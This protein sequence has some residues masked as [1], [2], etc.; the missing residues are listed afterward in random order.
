MDR[1]MA[2]Q[3]FACVVELGGFTQAVLCV[4]G[5]DSAAPRTTAANRRP[6]AVSGLAPCGRPHLH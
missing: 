6:G 5:A 2:L 4:A 3:A 1:R